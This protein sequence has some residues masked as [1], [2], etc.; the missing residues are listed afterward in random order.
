MSQ[1]RTSLLVY[2]IPREGM[3]PFVFDFAELGLAFD[4]AHAL[5][6]AL[7]AKMGHTSIQ[8]QGKAFM[9]LRK[10]ALCLEDNGKRD[11][12]PLPS[13]VLQL[14]ASWLDRSSLGPS[15]QVSLT[16]VKNLID[17]CQRN[18]SGVL[19]KNT[20]FVVNKIREVQVKPAKEGLSESVIKEILRACYDDIEQVEEER[21]K[22]R[23]LCSGKTEG[24]YEREL[25]LLMRDLM[26]AGKGQLATQSIYN[27]AGKSLARRVEDFGGSRHI[28]G[29]A[30]LSPKDILPF[31]VAIMAQSSANPESIKLAKADCI[32]NHPIRDDI[33]RIVW[34]KERSSREQ[35]ADFPKDKEWSAPNLVRRLNKLTEEVRQKAVRNSRN[36]L[37]ICYRWFDRS[38]GMPDKTAMLNELSYFIDRHS[39]PP[40]LFK[41]LRRTGGQIVQ[42]VRGSSGDAQRHLN[43]AQPNTTRLYTATPSVADAEDQVIHKHQVQ[44]ARLA[45]G[46]STGPVDEKRALLDFDLPADGMETTFG[47]RCKDPLAGIAPGSVRGSMCLKFFG[48]AS[49]PGAFIPLDNVDVVAR[50]LATAD[51]LEEARTRSQVEGWWRRFESFYEPIRLLVVGELLPAV[52]SPILQRAK[53]LVNPRLIPRLE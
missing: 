48:C 15:A 22:V 36:K 29:I 31:L 5:R 53:P 6:R 7:Q 39:L 19:A 46:E 52:S 23:R 2:K 27:R 17:W 13:N 10:L 42:A 8:T 14:F 26:E 21:S 50:L 11:I 47:F 32:V 41:D 25:L 3:Q 49:C 30:Y 9:A 4:V 37:F 1:S 20:S 51:A 16:K 34:V 35:R 40:F 33:E 12:S 45:R 43:H 24:P 18:V 44:F 28:A 38:V